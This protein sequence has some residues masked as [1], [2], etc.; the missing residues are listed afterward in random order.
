[1]P[2]KLTSIIRVEVLYNGQ[3]EPSVMMIGITMRQELYVVN[4]DINM[5]CELLKKMIMTVS[6]CD[7][8]GCGNHYYYHNENAGVECSSTSN[9]IILFQYRMIILHKSCEQ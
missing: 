7:H 8:G 3:W 1:V 5:L 2:S 9:V 6:T 4:W